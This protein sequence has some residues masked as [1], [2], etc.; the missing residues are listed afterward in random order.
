MKNRIEETFLAI[1]W[2]YCILAIARSIGLLLMVYTDDY[3]YN[4]EYNPDLFVKKYHQYIRAYDFFPS[5]VGLF[6]PFLLKWLLSIKLRWILIIIGVIGGFGIFIYLDSEYIRNVFYLFE[7]K[8]LNLLFHL[9]V[10][11]LLF[12]SITLWLIKRSYRLSKK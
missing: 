11:L 8:R 4:F 3:F 9:L 2:V 1:L 12:A 7:N 5:L 6:L 10:F